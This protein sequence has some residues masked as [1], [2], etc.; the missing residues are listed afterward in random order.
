M[1]RNIRFSVNWPFKEKA[2]AG[3]SEA[4]ERPLHKAFDLCHQKA[5]KA[6]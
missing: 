1:A 4:E 2:A 5:N 6:N 3:S